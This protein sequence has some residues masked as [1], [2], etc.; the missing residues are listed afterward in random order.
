MNS[1]NPPLA[2]HAATDMSAVG[3]GNDC[4]QFKLSHKSWL[5]GPQLQR[6]TV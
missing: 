6:V 5:A 4:M 3:W 1:H 2:R